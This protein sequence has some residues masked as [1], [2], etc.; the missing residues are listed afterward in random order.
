MNWGN[1]K[2]RE[3]YLLKSKITCKNLHMKAVDTVF[4]HRLELQPH[5]REEIIQ[6]I[7]NT[8]SIIEKEIKKLEAKLKRL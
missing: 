3:I 5:K 6:H 8:K 4:T 2:E 7:C 1:D